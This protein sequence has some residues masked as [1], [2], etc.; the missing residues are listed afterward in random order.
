MGLDYEQVIY[1]GAKPNGQQKNVKIF[2]FNSGQK[3][4]N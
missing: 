1:R 3:N 4:A 2:Q